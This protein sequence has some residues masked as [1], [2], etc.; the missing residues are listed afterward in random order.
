MQPEFLFGNL[1]QL[2]LITSKKEIIDSYVHGLEKMRNRYGDVVQFWIGANHF[3]A[4]CRPEHAEQIYSAR[5]IFDRAAL[6]KNTF[7]LIAEN[8][9][10][11]LMGPKYKRHAKAVLPMLRKNKFLSQISIMTNYVDQLIEIWKERYEN[12]DEIIATCIIDDNQQLLLDVFTRLTFD[13]DFGNLKRLL[14]SARQSNSA[15]I[16]GTSNFTAALITWLD[17]FKRVGTNGM[18][19]LVNYYLLKFDKKYQN[20][21]KVL[22]ISSLQQDESVEKFKSEEDQTGITKK[23]LLDE[24][25]SLIL[26]GFETTASVIS[27][28]IYYLSKQ[29]AI[30]Q[31][32]KNELKRNGITKETSLEDLDL[33]NQC[34]YI[35]CVIKETLRIAPLTIGSPRTITQDTVI[36]GIQLR[37]GEN[38]LVAFSLIFY[39]DDAPDR[40]HHPYV[41]S[42]FGNG[43]RVC[44][45]QDLA[46]LELKVIVIRLMLFVTFADAPG[47]NGGRRQRLSIMPKELAVYMKFD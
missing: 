26:G 37:Q 12:K 3:Y 45:G 31:K 6:R 9:L 16:V 1:R 29:P 18:P 46:R 40:N 7:G 44:V 5:H 19:F 42:P 32:M 39:G 28:M 8:A 25:L 38:V 15:E 47:N 4:F 34:E 24:V 41:F 43:H 2:D 27:W 20:A 14:E 21:L 23:E 10:I 36:D 22:E 13:Y 33:S 17:A 11:A 30:Q 35:D